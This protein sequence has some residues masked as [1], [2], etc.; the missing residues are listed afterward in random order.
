MQESAGE[1]PTRAGANSP[2]GAQPPASPPLPPSGRPPHEAAGEAADKSVSPRPYRGKLPGGG[3]PPAAIVSPGPPQA[4]EGGEAGE[5]PINSNAAFVAAVFRDL[6]EG[7]VAAVCSKRGDPERGGWPA[8]AAGRVDEQC[9][10]TRNNYFC[11][12]S[13]RRGDDGSL[14]ARKGSFAALHA[15]VLDDVGTKVPAERFAGF[16]FSWVIETSPGNHQAGVVLDPP[17]TDL[18]VAERL[19]NALVGKGLCDPG[20]RGAVRWARLPF[21]V[22]G[23]RKHRGKD[24]APFACRLVDLRA[25]RRCSVQQLAVALEL[26]L[27]PADRPGARMQAAAVAVRIADGADDV[28]SPRPAENPVVAAFKARGLYKRQI[29]TGKHDVTCPWVD[30]HTGAVDHGSAYFEPSD[31]FPLGGYR[32]QHSHGDR[33]RLRQLLEFLGVS[34]D[35]ARRE[36]VIRVL[37]GAIHRVVRAAETVLA[38]G[39]HFYQSGGLIVTI[40]VDPATGDASIVPLTQQALTKELARAARWERPDP[41]GGYIVCD[42]PQRH[43]SI[44]YDARHFERLPVLAGLARQPYFREDGE[45]VTQPG[46]DPVSQRFG[47]FDPALFPLPEPTAEAARAALALLLH[48]IE[49]FYFAGESDRSAA[50]SAILTAVVRVALCLAPGFHGHSPVSGSG[51]SK[52]CELIAA[53]AGPGSSQRVSYPTTSEEATKVLLSLL[54]TGP[55]VIEFDD[56]DTD[57]IPHGVINRIFTSATI[58]ERILGHSKTATVGTRVLILG[59]GNNVVPLRDLRR[60]VITIHLNPRCDTP[61]T[62]RYTRDP[63]RMVR[64]DRGKYVAAALTIIRAWLAAG[65]PR[66]D[67]DN[68]ASYGA[69][70]D[71]CRH[72]LIWLGLPDPATS[73]LEQVRHDPDADALRA[74]MT[75][76]RAIF[77]AS[78]TTVRKVVEAAA[79]PIHGDLHDALFELPVVERGEINRSRL[80][81]F[82]KKH[83]NRI[84]DGYEFRRCMADG[85]VAWQVVPAMPPHFRPEPAPPVSPPS[86]DGGSAP[87]PTGLF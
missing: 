79:N 50:L 45:L 8:V 34:E 4:G 19:I 54:L 48:L 43:V 29:E 33:Y 44:V 38:Q 5:P 42:P 86:G 75:A 10:P 28:F 82:L 6:P 51:K 25:Q 78:P 63:V 39:G 67:V 3:A 30:E 24:G 22:N 15:I 41:R 11:I 49:E 53:F 18:T 55:A 70:A 35:E 12:A 85:R 66:A 71:Y 68:I 65:S 7:A 20:A 36:N 77:G 21:G 72:P 80:G 87:D 52:L 62:L 57:W 2:E 69:W 60:R 40:A 31:G 84:V 37:P 58:S 26:D 16:E 59:S 83:A 74:L 9:Q 73:L 1:Q 64:V 47:A 61:A 81:W 27:A 23:K 17:V 13:L 46:Y 76:W 32:C 14:K 56:M